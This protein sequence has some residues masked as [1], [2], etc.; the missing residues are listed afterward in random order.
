[1][2][3]SIRT[4][5]ICNQSDA[6]APPPSRHIATFSWVKPPV[7]PDLASASAHQSASCS[8]KRP[9]V[10]QTEKDI[11]VI[12]SVVQAPDASEQGTDD[13]HLPF[14]LMRLQNPGTRLIYV[15]A[16]PIAPSRIEDYL[17]HLPATLLP[18]PHDR[19]TLLSTGDLSGRSLPEQILRRPSLIHR[20]KQ[21][22]RPNCAVM[23]C[24]HS[25]RLERELALTLGIPL[26]ADNLDLLY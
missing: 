17:K 8:N 19:L 22:L 16:Q 5:S 3:S 26:F 2:P 20:I 1:M 25:T 13:E 9:R 21:S 18:F 23:A 11:V 15:S 24:D 12:S 4:Q 7:N 6:I 14:W 10:K